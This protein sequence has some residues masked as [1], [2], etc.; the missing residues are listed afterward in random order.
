MKNRKKKLKNQGLRIFFVEKIFIN[1]CQLCQQ[2]QQCQ[3]FKKPK[4]ISYVL[5]NMNY[6]YDLPD[7]LQEKIIDMKEQIELEELLN[8]QRK[9]MK[10]RRI[11]T[12]KWFVSV[13]YDTDDHEGPPPPSF[14]EWNKF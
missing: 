11:N 14:E 7:C 1:P 4:I 3:P 5:V 10:Q 9:Y 12:Y 8:A 2:C 6:F 13:W